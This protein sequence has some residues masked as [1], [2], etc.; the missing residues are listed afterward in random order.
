MPTKPRK[1]QKHD[2]SFYDFSMIIGGRTLFDF[3]C[4][5][6]EYRYLQNLTRCEPTNRALSNR[7]VLTGDLTDEKDLT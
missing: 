6:P 4:Q 5:N 3:L 7:G 2:N 1:T